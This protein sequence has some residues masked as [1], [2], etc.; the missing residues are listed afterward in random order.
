M[1]APDRDKYLW[2]NGAGT[3]LRWGRRA[4]SSAAAARRLSGSASLPSINHLWRRCD[5]QWIDP[6]FHQKHADLL[7]TTVL[8]LYWR[9]LWLIALRPWPAFEAVPNSKDRSEIAEVSA[10]DLP[11][12]AAALFPSLARI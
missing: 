5:L 12:V 10:N 9:S 2:H 8:D 6:T 4:M 11:S 3:P 1:P 7:D